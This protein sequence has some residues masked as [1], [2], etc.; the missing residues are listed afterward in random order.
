MYSENKRG[1]IFNL[2]KYKQ[3]KL[4]DFSGLQFERKITPTDIDLII[5]FSNKEWVIGEFK[6]KGTD[7]PYGQKLCLERLCKN[8]TLQTKQVL[9]FIAFH[10]TSNPNQIIKASECI[11]TEIWY[12]NTW[13]ESSPRTVRDLIEKWRQYNKK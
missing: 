12:D 6:T 9:G 10:Q 7:I 2:E 1:E 4:L 3:A 5:D 13:K 8:L 11:V